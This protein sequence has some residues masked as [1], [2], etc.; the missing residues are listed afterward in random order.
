V[1]SGWALPPQP[2]CAPVLTGGPIVD[3]VWRTLLDRAGPRHDLALTDDPGLHLL[4][5]GRRIDPVTRRAG[6]Y[7][8]M[9]PQAP[10]SVHIVSRS[11]VP[12]ELGLARDPRELGVAVRQMV[13][14]GDT[15]EATLKAGAAMLTD[16]WHGFESD[17]DIRWT[18]GDA[19][20]P[21]EMFAN[22]GGDLW[23]ML[24]LGGTTHYLDYGEVG[25]AA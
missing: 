21:S 16:G 14:A 13:A 22:L 3:R 15:S 18:N 19:A 17:C 20:I 1:N 11:A 4:V 2:P 9:L 5:D 8:F 12:A 25:Q 24:Y 10:R 7:V 23:L 6:A